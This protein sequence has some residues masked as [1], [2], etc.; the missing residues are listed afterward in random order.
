MN[1]IENR[2]LFLNISS[3]LLCL[4]PIAL[5]T[6]PFLP[7]LFLSII[8]LLYLIFFFK[9]DKLDFLFLKISISIGLAFYFI[10]VLG[11]IFSENILISLKSSL[12]IEVVLVD[13]Y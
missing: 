5:V 8:S 13:T 3:F 9:N 6:G 10:I 2:N 12:F 7:D 11:S 4:I 1:Q